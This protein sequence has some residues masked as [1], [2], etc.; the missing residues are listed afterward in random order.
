MPYF[1]KRNGYGYICRKVK[2]NG[3]WKE[4]TLESLGKI[5]SKEA[6][7]LIEWVKEHGTEIEPTTEEKERGCSIWKFDEEKEPARTLLEK[8]YDVV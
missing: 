8:V 4:E 6:E 2:K 1:R 3:R 7:E 5:M